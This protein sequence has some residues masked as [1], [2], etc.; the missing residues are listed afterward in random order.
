MSDVL[1]SKS[2]SQTQTESMNQLKTPSKYGFSAVGFDQLGA[3]EYTLATMVID[4]SGSVA[5]FLK[6][7][8]KCM[9]TVLSSCKNSPRTDNLL[10]RAMQFSDRVKELHGFRLLADVD[11]KEYDGILNVGGS[12]SLFDAVAN[13]TE[14]TGTLGESLVNQEFKANGVIYVIT[15]GMDNMS[16][17]TPNSIRKAL[18]KIGKD[19]KLESIAI[20]L[21]M[22]GA[23]DPQAKRELDTFV[24]DAKITQFVDMTDLFNKQSPDKALAKLA[25][26]ISRSISTTSTALAS[27]TSSAVS[28]KLTI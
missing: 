13:A 1:T 18:D 21:I 11:P 16:K 27:G 14:A 8:E 23:S 26:Y 10:L 15:D 3:T 6:D 9:K 7:L 24:Q 28:S 4:A 12:T 19:E 22:V 17:S 25:G 2:I 20:I 5:Y